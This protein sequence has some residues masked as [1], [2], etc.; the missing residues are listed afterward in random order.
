MPTRTPT[1]S[2][3]SEPTSRRRSGQRL[4]PAS[5][6]GLY[7]LAAFTTAGIWTSGS[8]VD[9]LRETAGNDLTHRQHLPLHWG[10]WDKWAAWGGALTDLS[11]IISWLAP[12]PIWGKRTPISGS[13]DP[14]TQS[15]ASLI[16]LHECQPRTAAGWCRFWMLMTKLTGAGKPTY[17]PKLTDV[18]ASPR[19]RLRNREPR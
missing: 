11:R 3:I 12:R 2:C 7:H 14:P 17:T 19:P 9:D 5:I 13:G 8:E 10:Y 16:R 4:P 15:V 18:T 1:A 6:L